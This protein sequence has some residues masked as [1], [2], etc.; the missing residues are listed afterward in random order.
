MDKATRR[1]IR[2]LQGLRD[3]LQSGDDSGLENAW[4]EFC[5]QVQYE[6]SVFFDA[7]EET[8]RAVL[9]GHLETLPALDLEVAW[10]HTDAGADW[11]QA[12]TEEHS[13][14]PVCLD[15]VLDDALGIVFT[16]AANWSNQRIRGY[17]ERANAG[18]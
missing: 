11:L 17:L 14:P 5:V 13:P 18:D 2:T 7:Y 10:L 8:V 6:E 4:D 15:H 12:E 3:G 9:R 1:T 16:M